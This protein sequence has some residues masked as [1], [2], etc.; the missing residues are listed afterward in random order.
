MN[1]PTTH[2][3]AA[4]AS[5]S[6]FGAARRTAR[7]DAASSAPKSLASI[8]AGAGARPSNPREAGS[9]IYNADEAGNPVS[10]N[11]DPNETE[12]RNTK[13]PLG[14]EVRVLVVDDDP[15]DVLI[16]ERLLR[17]GGRG[18]YIVTSTSDTAAAGEIVCNG[19]VDI[20]LVDLYLGG[21]SGAELIAGLGGREAPVPM[22]MLTTYAGEK[23][24]DIA[25]ACGATDYVD[26]SSLNEAV[27]QR[28]IRY[29]LHNHRIERQLRER[30]FEARRAR[31]EALVANRAKSDFLSH[32]SH[33]LRTPLNAIIGFAELLLSEAV[34]PLGERGRGYVSD[35]RSSGEHLLGI[36]NSLLDITK[37]EAGTFH[38]DESDFS[39]RDLIL[40]S[41]RLVEGSA[42]FD[43]PGIDVSVEPAN[44]ALRADRR[45]MRQVM[46]NL[47]ANAAKFTPTDRKI[48]ASARLTSEGGITLAVADEGEGIHRDDLETVLQPFGQV[49]NLGQK[50]NGVGLGLPLAVRLTAQHDG[51]LRLESELGVGTSVYITL[52]PERVRKAEP[53]A[54]LSA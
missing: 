11:T 31:D 3:Q 51:E 34:E 38:L 33:E 40:E 2:G 27:L 36:I 12:S 37:I 46:V 7:R 44:L 45:C 20:A 10:T 6:E 39:V 25:L 52:P 5:A 13:A 16:V 53:E 29:A 35:V 14:Q 41:V 26:K 54:K 24:D 18:R 19:E 28:S 8:V 21:D 48:H 49:G 32:M 43:S 30:E 9:L 17:H 4:G 1:T 50:Q 47:L 42:H 23:S 22:I 15:E